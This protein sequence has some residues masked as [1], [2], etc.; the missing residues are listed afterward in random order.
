MRKA[1][2][3]VV[4]EAVT[5]ARG[6]I[7]VRRTEAP[8]PPSASEVMLAVATVALRVRPRGIQG[9]R[10]LYPLPMRQGHE[11]SARIKEFG[12]GSSSTSS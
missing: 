7:E 1:P 12:A 11:N 5:V 9:R 6:R 2:G 8:Q 10:P 3:K 4:L